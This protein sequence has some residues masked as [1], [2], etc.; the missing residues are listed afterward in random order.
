MAGLVRKNEQAKAQ[1]VDGA[2]GAEMA[3]LIGVEDGAPN[4]LTRRF[5]LNPGGSIP[6]HRHPAIEHEQVVLSGRML[7]GI[8]EQTHMVEAGDAVYIPSGVAH[9]YRNEGDQP[10]QFL[11]M[12]PRTATYDTEWLDD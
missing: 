6:R 2:Q 8:G 3:V 9:W 4:F 1:P 11:C 12:V 5:T 7:L 10:V